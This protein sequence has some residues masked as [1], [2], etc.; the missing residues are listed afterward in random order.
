LPRVLVIAVSTLLSALA[1]IAPARATFPGTNG[2]ITYING[3]NRVFCISQDGTGMTNFTDSRIGKDFGYVRIDWS[4]DGAKLL[5]SYIVPPVPPTVLF[6]SGA[7]ASTARFSPNI[8]YARW[9]PD[10][11]SIVFHR[12]VGVP[13]SNTFEINDELDIADTNGTERPLTRNTDRA[14]TVLDRFP[15]WSPDGSRVA[16]ARNV[17]AAGT[18]LNYVI[19]QI[20]LINANGTGLTPITD[21]LHYADALDWS[22]DGAKIVYAADTNRGGA[23]RA[24]YDIY[25][26]GGNGTGDTRL[27]NDPSYEYDPVWSPDGKSIA[28]VSSGELRG[29]RGSIHVMNSDGSNNRVL[30]SG[31]APDWGIYTGACT[32]GP[33]PKV[34]LRAAKRQRLGTRPRVQVSA[35]CDVACAVTASASVQVNQSGKLYRNRTRRVKRSL[36]AA[37]TAA[38]SLKFSKKA[39]VAIRHAVGRHRKLTARVKVVARGPG[40]KAVAKRKIKLTR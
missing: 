7:L 3:R 24:N 21:T 20:F 27:T 22:P 9:S 30:T 1:L 26:I 19:G 2:K 40:G 36:R 6:P 34:T 15:S 31:T 17:H 28:Y 11:R 39:A 8:D 32:A 16:F 29:S 14:L 37:T 25:V 5:F 18:T 33:P 23:G 38:L 35:R 13:G 10:A 4:P 12:G